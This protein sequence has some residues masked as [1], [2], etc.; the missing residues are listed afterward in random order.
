MFL[1]VFLICMALGMV[2][3]FLAGLLGIGGGLIIV[4]ALV[5]VLPMLNIQGEIALHIALATSLASIVVTSSTAALNHYKLGNIPVPLAKVLMPFVAVGAVLGAVLADEMSTKALTTFFSTFV[6]LLACYMLFSIRQTVHRNLPGK[7]A[8][9][10]VAVITGVIASLM[11]ISGGAILVPFLTYCGVNIL[12]SIGVATACGMIVSLFGTV[13]YIFA[14]IG[15][16]NLPDWSVG[17]VYLPAVLGISLTSTI[18]ARYGV[19]LA[20]QLPVKTIKKV[21]AAFLIVVAVEMMI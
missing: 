4:P 10:I 7:P 8:L 21:F 17:Y 9:R 1:T 20:T 13:A 14:G 11:G 12:R 19:K 3:G 6:I 16:H 5:F 15:H 18:L 2:V